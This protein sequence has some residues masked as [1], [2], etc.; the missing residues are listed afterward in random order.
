MGVFCEM[1]ICIDLN[2]TKFVAKFRKF[3]SF[4]VLPIACLTPTHTHTN[5]HTHTTHT[6]TKKMRNTERK[7]V[8]V[9]SRIDF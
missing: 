9:V 7:R 4:S 1:H 3:Y 5:K 6:K 8:K 2:L